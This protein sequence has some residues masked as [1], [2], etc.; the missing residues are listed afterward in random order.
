MKNKI[1]SAYSKATTRPAKLGYI[2]ALIDV[3]I[4]VGYINLF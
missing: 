1:Q 4:I 3:V 2:I